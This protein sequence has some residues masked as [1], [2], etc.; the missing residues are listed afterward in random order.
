MLLCVLR[1]AAKP[2]AGGAS[3]AA[4]FGR[5]KDLTNRRACR[6]Q[7]DCTNLPRFRGAGRRRQAEDRGNAMLQARPR[8]RTP[9]NRDRLRGAGARRALQRQGKSIV[10]LGIGQPDFKTPAHIVEAADQGAARRPP[11]LHARPGH[12]AAARGGRPRPEAPPRRRGAPRHHRHLA[13]RQADHVLLD[14][15]LRAARRRDPLSRPRLSHLPLHDRVHRRQ[16][17]ADRAERGQRVQLHR[18]PGAL[19]RSRPRPA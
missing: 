13:G 12:P 3:A 14:P 11:R 18:R 8:T 17:G 4:V 10:N 2:A 6:T 5:T 15:D 19:A 16:A 1:I 7:A 9:G